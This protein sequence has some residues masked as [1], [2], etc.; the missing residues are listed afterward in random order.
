MTLAQ[1]S[2]SK[3]RPL[4]IFGGGIRMGRIFG[5]ELSADWSLLIIFALVAVNLGAAVLPSWHPQWAA[6]LTWL[7]ALGAAVLFFVSVL[8]H[9]ISHA[10]VAKGFGMK[11]RGIT[12][13]MFGGVS[14][15]EGEPPHARAEFFVAVVGPITSLVIGVVASLAGSL[16]GGATLAEAGGDPM[17]AMRNLGPVA[18][19]LFWLGPVNII[20][21]VFNMVPGFP[22][23]G[24]RVLRSLLWWMTGSLQRATHYASLVGQV[25][26]WALITMGVLMAFGVHVPFFGTGAFQGL[27]LILIGWFLNNAARMSY[28]QLLIRQGLE[29]VPVGRL[30]YSRV[31]TIEPTMSVGQLVRDKIMHS[32][33]RCFPVIEEGRLEGLVCLDDVRKAPEAEWDR[34]PVGRIMTPRAKLSTLSPDDEAQQALQQLAEEGYDQIPVV[35]HGELRGLVRRQDIMKWL[36]LQ[37]HPT[38]A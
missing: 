36:K 27:W 5:L 23:D 24:G 33:Q 22:L 6:G 26:A 11:V 35:D 25:F 38:G 12:L 2:T 30:M 17:L 15:I 28:Q 14:Q 9:E 18:T 8:A 16:I 4:T 19:L 31:E 3:R 34:T 32:D 7:V 37:Q 10:L 1:E 29:N 13:F 20:L 21:A